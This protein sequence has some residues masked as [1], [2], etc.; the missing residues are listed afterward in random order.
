MIACVVEMSD[1]DITFIPRNNIKSQVLTD[2]LIELSSPILEESY[3][4]W[5]LSVDDSSN[6]KGNGEGIMLEEP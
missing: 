6:L 4:Q 2:F 5:V 1:Y 3:E